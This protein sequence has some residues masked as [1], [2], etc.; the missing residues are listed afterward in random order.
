MFRARSGLFCL[1]AAGILTVNLTV[2]AG[3]AAYLTDL[4]ANLCAAFLSALGAYFLCGGG[5]KRLLAVPCLIAAMAL[6][7]AMLS[8]CLVL[9]M[10]DSI[11]SFLRNEKAG[12]TVTKGLI[13]ALLCVF[14]CGI[15][16]LLTKA[17]C[18]IAGV[19]PAETYNG[20][21]RFS[22]IP[23]RPSSPL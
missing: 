2:T 12:N 5:K 9:V 8:V 17:V 18:R 20:L 19:T 13:S 10:A 21:N 6:Y 16:L 15:Y 1:L 7:Q 11:L 3:A 4:D 14:S 22:I 23:E